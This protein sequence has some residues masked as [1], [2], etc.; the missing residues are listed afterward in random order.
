MGLGI[1]L[2]GADTNDDIPDD[3]L[4]HESGRAASLLS[5]LLGLVAMVEQITL[6]PAFQR[7]KVETQ[8]VEGRFEE[9]MNMAM[10]VVPA[11]VCKYWGK[12]E[13]KC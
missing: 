9:M 6:K 10:L 1:G 13:L 8:Y 5:M 12:K 11:I 3:M 2:C 4:E 7:I